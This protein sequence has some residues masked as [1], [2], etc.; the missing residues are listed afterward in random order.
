MKVINPAHTYEL[1][2]LEGTN[3]QRIQFIH[4]VPNSEGKFETVQDG[5]T[6]EEVLLMLIHRLQV[7]QSRPST[8][9]VE[10]ANAIRSLEEALHWL[11]LRIKLRK[12]QGVHE[13]TSPHKS[14]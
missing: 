1:K 13:T 14:V 12:K 2:S 10:N 4:K 7:F 11:T 5:T 6:N 9:C 8:M 3:P